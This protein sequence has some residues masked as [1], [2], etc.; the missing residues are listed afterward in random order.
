VK[1]KEVARA[2]TLNVEAAEGKLDKQ[3]TGGYVGDLLSHVMA[4][5][6]QGNIWITV[7][8]HPNIVAVAVVAGLSGI[9]VAEGMVIDPVTIQKAEEEG[10]PLFSTPMSCFAVVSGLVKAGLN[11]TR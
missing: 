9:V 11:N 1:L 5:A 2:L 10:I 6:Q 3:V 7:Q 8:A 4:K